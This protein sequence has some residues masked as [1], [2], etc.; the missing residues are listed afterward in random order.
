MRENENEN[1]NKENENKEQ[2][3]K[4]GLFIFRRDLRLEDNTTLNILSNLCDKLY[5]IFIFTP[6]QVGNGNEYKSNNAVQFMVES[7]ENLS[8]NIRK[9]G[10]HLYTFYGK[11]NSIIEKCIEAFEINIVGFNYDITP[12]S[13]ERDAQIIKLCEKKDIFVVYDND[14]YLHY[15]G[16]IK[17]G[18]GNPYLKFTPYYNVAKTKQVNKPQKLN[19]KL[20]HK[21]VK[22]LHLIDLKKATKQFV[23]INENLL[24]HG[25]RE[26]AIKQLKTAH[27]N[28]KHYDA[29]RNTLTKE[30]SLL[31]AYI[32][33]GC[34]SIREVYYAFKSNHAFIRQL[35]WRDFYAQVLY[36]YPDSLEHALKPKYNKIK[37]NYND[38][39][40]NAW[41]NGETGF[42]I[43]D[44]CMR[45]MNT[46]G[47][48]H[49]RGRLIVSSFLV[50]TLLISW[51]KGAQYFSKCLTDYS[52]EN[53]QLNWQWTASTG[54]D[55]QPYFR[56]FN[57][58]LQQKEY[59]E[60]CEFIK[61]WIPELENVDVK[62]IHN[63]ETE[64]VNYKDVKYPKPICDY[65]EQKEKAL[66]MYKEIY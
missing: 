19:I 13:R 54:A 66:K 5:T 50:K 62:I 21:S 8:S 36:F 44:A 35:H 18:T 4:N 15:P 59:D 32:K 23:K 56:I 30:T 1:E 34:V 7:L 6:E 65:K 49:N 33:F 20:H 53:N 47:Y 16:S 37:W 22:L 9:H 41:K 45:Q 38:R 27:N 24:V 58:F 29:T 39:W 51:Q 46:T 12:Y 10:G 55:S 17:N 31:S 42:P 25:G 26:N 28:V 48:M 2:K 52:P 61:K 57:P 40:F 60:N 11:N 64:W 43:V 3:S 63:W 14:Y